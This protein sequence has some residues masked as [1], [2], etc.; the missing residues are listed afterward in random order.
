M[1][2]TALA[3][4]EPADQFIYHR[5]GPVTLYHGDA[6]T[7]LS[8][9]AAASVDTVVTSPPYYGLRN[10]DV[11]GQYGLESTPTDYVNTMVQV[12]TQIH[13]VLRD[14]GTA[15]LVLGDS[16]SLNSGGAPR[17]GTYAGYRGAATANPG[18]IRPRTQDV[19]PAKNLIGIP[20]RVAFALQDTR[21]WYLRQAIIWHKP[22]ATPESVQDRPSCSHEYVFLLAKSRV[23]HFNLDAIRVPL[24]QPDARDG[25]RVIGGRN[26][27]STGGVGPTD[28]RRGATAYGTNPAKYLSDPAASPGQAGRRHLLATGTQHTTAHAKGRNPGSVWSIPTRPYSGAH[29]AVYPLDLPAAAVA[30]GCPPGGRVLDPFSGAATTGVA[31]LQQGRQYWG[32]DIKAAYH[33]LAIQRLRR[34]T[35][36]QDPP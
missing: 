4:P 3:A 28:R 26:K 30:A 24:A 16:Y 27:G 18:L 21:L 32:I 29:F 25:S 1:T 15:W 22:N 23:Y 13:R 19:L 9:L 12:F 7:V 36:T 34:H 5:D 2:R 6:H 8:A 10:Y 17:S 11:P 14:H 20:W 31:A 35:S 33:D